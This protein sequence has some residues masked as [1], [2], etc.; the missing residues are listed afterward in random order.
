LGDVQDPT[1]EQEE[2]IKEGKLDIFTYRPALS[3]TKKN[4]KFKDEMPYAE[5]ANAADLDEPMAV[6]VQALETKARSDDDKEVL[7]SGNDLLWIVE[8]TAV[9]EAMA[10]H[11]GALADYKKHMDFILNYLKPGARM[12]LSIPQRAAADEVLAG[13]TREVLSYEKR[14]L[15]EACCCNDKCHN[16][17]VNMFVKNAPNP[18]DDA[19]TGKHDQELTCP[20][21]LKARKKC[22]YQ[23]KACKKK[24]KLAA[25]SHQQSTARAFLGSLVQLDNLRMSKAEASNQGKAEFKLKFQQR[26]THKKMGLIFKGDIPNEFLEPKKDMQEPSKGTLQQNIGGCFDYVC[27]MTSKSPDY[28][29]VENMWSALAN[30]YFSY[31]TTGVLG[32]KASN[33]QR[34][35]KLIDEWLDVWQIFGKGYSG[36]MWIYS[37]DR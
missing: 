22:T 8:P 26:W 5:L 30:E 1:P 28:T 37:L 3:S 10:H 2:K 32:D 29:R 11:E 21:W 25:L 23:E 12:K 27:L 15:G 18:A 13:H 9:E 34:V 35:E 24:W 16:P 14:P 33:L 7:K 4:N 6:R 19:C 31:T 17:G 20:E 36:K